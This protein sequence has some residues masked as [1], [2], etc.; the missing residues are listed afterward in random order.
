MINDKTMV[1]RTVA[2]LTN[3]G[4]L[5]KEILI[6]KALM[7]HGWH[8]RVPGQ[9]SVS[10]LRTPHNSWFIT[11]NDYLSKSSKTWNDDTNKTPCA[12]HGCDLEH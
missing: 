6:K 9:F 3:H 12:W 11:V 7:C 10:C 4:V 8:L 5:P 1:Q 2:M